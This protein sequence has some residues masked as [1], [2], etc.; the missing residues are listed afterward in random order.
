LDIIIRNIKKICYT[1]KVHLV[2]DDS[3]DLLTNKIKEE[4]IEN[5]DKKKKRIM[6]VATLDTCV[7]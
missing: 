5:D 2:V 3:E 6:L 1:H 7:I 4:S